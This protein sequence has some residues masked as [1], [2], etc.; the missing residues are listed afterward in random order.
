MGQFPVLGESVVPHRV[1]P[2]RVGVAVGVAPAFPS[3][4]GARVCQGTG[5]EHASGAAIKLG[6]LAQSKGHL[7]LKGPSGRVNF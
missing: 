7:F 4:S 2:S 1:G 6:G 5:G 3:S